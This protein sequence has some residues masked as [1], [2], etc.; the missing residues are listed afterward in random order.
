MGKLTNI[1]SGGHSDEPLD[2][3]IYD[4]L[5][6]GHKFGLPDLPIPKNANFKYR[7]DPV[8]QQVTNLLMR[9]GKKSV[10]QRVSS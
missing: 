5:V 7:D 9:D 8:V 3:K 1:S 4:P 2:T 10:A 6:Q